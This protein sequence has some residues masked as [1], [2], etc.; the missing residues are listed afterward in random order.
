MTAAEVVGFLDGYGGRST[1]RCTRTPRSSGCARRTPASGSTPTSGAWRCRAVVVA[2]GAY[3]GRGCPPSPRRC[4]PASPRSPRWSTATRHS[5]R[6][7][8][9]WSSAPRRR[10]CSSPTSC[11]QRPAGHAR[12]RRARPDAAHLPR[13]RHPPLDG[14]ARGPRRALR[15][16]GGPGPGAAAA[17]AAARRARRA[18]HGGPRR[19]AAAGV[20]LAGRFVGVA[21]GRARFSGSLRHRLAAADLKLGRLLARIDEH[22]AE[23]GPGGQVGRPERPGPPGSRRRRASWTWPGS[24]PWSGRPATGRPTRGW[25]RL[26]S[27]AAGDP[28]RRRGAP[29]AGLYV[30]GLPLPR[31][32]H[33][34]LLDGV[35]DD[36]REIT[37]QLSGPG[38]T[39]PDVRV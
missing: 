25:T 30:L 37:A 12:G 4:P 23:H 22:V 16:G 27:T 13:P 15:R 20:E 2:T 3:A 38:W 29:G 33:S 9:C 19:A 39:E 35:G 7:A 17:V 11:A 8:A 36:A 21:G 32:R 14:R 18:A 28:P 31:K 10:A 26:C 5:S 24:P 6:R 1:R 34:T